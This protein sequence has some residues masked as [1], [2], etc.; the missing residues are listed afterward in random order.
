MRHLDCGTNLIW[1]VVFSPQS[2]LI[3]LLNPV[4]NRPSPSFPHPPLC[5][6]FYVLSFLFSLSLIFYS[7]SFTNP[8]TGITMRV[9][10]ILPKSAPQLSQPYTIPDV[11]WVFHPPPLFFFSSPSFGKMQSKSCNPFC[12]GVGLKKVV[13][14]TFF[15]PPL[16]GM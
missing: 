14:W 1:T 16:R 4:V 15:L 6:F 2:L 9:M 3:F 10:E 13:G 11:P 12:E 8:L 7:D 5:F